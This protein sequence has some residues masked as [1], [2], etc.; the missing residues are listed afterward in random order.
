MNITFVRRSLILLASIGAG[1]VLSGCDSSAPSAAKP[2]A[3]RLV[4]SGG[5]KHFKASGTNKW[6]YTHNS[7]TE[8]QLWAA[9][10]EAGKTKGQK[11]AGSM[12]VTSD[13]PIK[14][15]AIL[16][17]DGDTAYEGSGAVLELKPNQPQTLN[18]THQFQNDYPRI[19]LQFDVLECSDPSVMFTIDD[20]AIRKVS[21]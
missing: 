15:S 6:S 16:A 10:F 3:L 4:S 20:V 11:Y 13:K 19:K 2:G 18:L 14:L 7:A 21:Q 8:R 5:D 12:K 1:F 9:V 17:R